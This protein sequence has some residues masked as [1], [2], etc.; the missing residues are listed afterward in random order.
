MTD[1]ILYNNNIMSSLEA[2]NINNNLCYRYLIGRNNDLNRTIY[3]Q[4][5]M[6]LF[7]ID[8]RLN[9]ICDKIY[10]FLKN[11]LKLLPKKTSI[12]YTPL[13]YSV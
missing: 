5:R 10:E 3:N 9:I 8:Y 12:S 7:S 11:E 1:N 6:V 2:N 13:P 4:I